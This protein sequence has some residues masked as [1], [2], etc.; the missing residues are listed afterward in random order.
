MFDY[1]HLCYI[2]TRLNAENPPSS[3]VLQC[4]SHLL[5]IQL[6]SN[7]LVCHIFL[8]DHLCQVHFVFPSEEENLVADQ[9]EF[10]SLLSL[11]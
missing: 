5:S 1:V 11:V 2:V 4:I 3:M 8:K 6:L 10:V 7:W 9:D